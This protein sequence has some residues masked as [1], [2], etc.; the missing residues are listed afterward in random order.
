MRVRASNQIAIG[1]VL[2]M[3]GVYGGYRVVTARLIDSAVF[4]EIKPGRINLVGIDTGA[5]Y[6]IIVSNQMA[7][8][9][10]SLSAEALEAGDQ[11]SEE[12]G[13]KRRVPLKELLQ[14]LQGKGEALGPFVTAMNDELRQQ[15]LPSN[16]EE[17][18]WTP[19]QV[20]LALGGDA[21]LKAKLERQLNI[22]LDGTP[23]EHVSLS[24][25][26]D[27][28]YLKV[29]VSLSVPV[30]GQPTTVE[31]HIYTAYKARFVA[32]IEMKVGEN[33][34]DVN[35]VRGAYAEERARYLGPTGTRED[36][37]Q[38]LLDR[39][40]PASV[41]KFLVNPQRVLSKAKVV[42]NDGFLEKAAMQEVP[43]SDG[44]KRYDVTLD[45]SDEGRRRLW[46]YSRRNVGSQLLLVADG[47]AVAAPR[48]QHE[49]AAGDVTIKQLPDET[50]ATDLVD[51]VN[52]IAAARNPK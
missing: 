18:S 46:Q 15:Q 41:E 9:V 39:V 47:A 7:Q 25:V 4:P 33:A 12:E 37:R 1:F 43:A 30:A 44:K 17:L 49:L 48:I 38:S 29:P 28:I 16:L 6:R 34:E 52:Q 5:G 13:A 40:S 42:V 35:F 36:I 45:L 21:A 3:A 31:G 8:L 20:Q 22:G 50:L 19:E 11:E 23:P 27:G 2:L 32:Q 10:E 26:F 14:V 24:A 51:A